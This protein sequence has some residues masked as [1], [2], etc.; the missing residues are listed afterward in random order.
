MAHF[1]V[2]LFFVHTSY[3]LMLS[4]DRLATRH[5][6]FGKS[7]VVFYIRRAFR[8]YPLV[9]IIV[10]VAT[11]LGSPYV[12][13][14][15]ANEHGGA[16]LATY[17]AN[18]FLVQNLVHRPDTF[19]T[20]WT[21]PIEVQAYLFLPFC[22]V[23]AK[24]NLKFAIILGFLSLSAGVLAYISQSNIFSFAVYF[25]CFASGILA[26]AIT[27]HR[28]DLQ[29]L[30]GG[31][32]ATVLLMTVVA[33][34][35]IGLKFEPGSGYFIGYDW[36]ASL[37]IALLIPFFKDMSLSWLS[38]ASFQ[39]ARYS[40]GIYLFHFPVMAFTN[41]SW[42]STIILTGIA[43]VAAYHFIEGPLIKLGKKLTAKESSETDILLA[44]PAP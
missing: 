37:C 33:L 12:Y 8:I 26:Y 7:A 18:L 13:P 41:N 15:A 4:L 38:R 11:I 1:G 39:V 30:N 10:T 43:S 9:M 3:V 27:L 31:L 35:F 40:Y 16:M 34:V 17:F 29:K 28:G 19:G 25:P 20:L 22:F 24:R 32:W 42:L 6:G 2:V 23:L 5:M 44:T 14:P 21:L 36:A